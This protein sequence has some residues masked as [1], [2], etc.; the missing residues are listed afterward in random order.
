MTSGLEQKKQHDFSLNVLRR[1][2]LI[3]VI[4]QT[5]PGK[6]GVIVLFAGFESEYRS[7]RQESSFY[8]LTGITEP[9]VA[10]V[11]D[12]HGQSTL[13]IPNCADAR[14]QWMSASV[15][16]T[17]AN[18][19]NIG[20]NTV[21]TLGGSCVGYQF[22]PFFPRAEYETLLADLSKLIESQ[23]TIFTLSP[24]NAYGYVEQRL[25]LKRLE[26]FLPGLSQSIV[27]ISPLVAE[28]RRIKDMR[29][30]ESL[31]SAVEITTMAHE[32]AARAIE[33]DVMEC[34]VQA[35]LEYIFTAAG[36]TQSFPS[37]VGSGK[38]S[39]VLHYTVNSATMKNGDL[40]VVDIGA[41]FGHYAADLTRTYPVSG[42]F[43]KRQ[44]EVYNVVLETQ[45]YI[46]DIAKPGYW[47]NNKDVP[48]KSLNHL[49]KAFLAKK[50]YEKYF[51]HG[52]GHYLG[53]DVHDVGDYKKP[54]EVG[55]VFTIEPGIYIPTESI[56]VRIEDDYWVVKDGV[57]CLSDQL[58]KKA[59]DIEA[60]MSQRDDEDEDEKKPK[61][62]M[63]YDFNSD[64]D[65]DESY[66]A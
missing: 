17:Q 19:T 61:S 36:A 62:D 40:V 29:E 65:E 35:T 53:L 51:I 57:V 44:R 54:L 16:L 32:A 49:A 18:A 26:E 55:D 60:L 31:Y 7:F 9:G 48:E 4:K 59:E 50:G 15:A 27:D 28:Q 22:H 37:I 45:E 52:I 13:Y 58:P 47:L 2:D 10:L 20:I 64:D 11:V 30:I 39:T 24:N 8:Y 3:S 5:H 33:H 42:K 6:D 21:S 1:K 43:T 23:K 25:V 14:S 66:E 41:E 56:G 34:E 38:N 46:A 63:G 12:L